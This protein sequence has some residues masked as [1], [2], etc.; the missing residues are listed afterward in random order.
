MSSFEDSSSSQDMGLLVQSGS[1]VVVDSASPDA[2]DAEDQKTFVEAGES[3]GVS[4]DAADAED[5]D[6]FAEAKSARPY[7]YSVDAGP[8]RSG[9]RRS[10]L[11]CYRDYEL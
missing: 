3:A 1:S 5:Q 2:A 8:P 10:V 9:R 6:T 7:E 4:C 11:T